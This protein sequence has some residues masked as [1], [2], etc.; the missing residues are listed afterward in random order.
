VSSDEPVEMTPE[1]RELVE[2]RWREVEVADLTPRQAEQRRLAEQMRAVIDHLVATTAPEEALRYAADVLQRLAVEFEAY[3][4]ANTY[5]GF[6]EAANA[7]GDQ[8]AFF[9]HSPLI[10]QAN[11]LA[12]PVVIR[13]EDDHIDG[14]VTFGAAYE[15]PPGCVHGGYLAAAFD[16]VLGAA[17]SLGGRPGMTGTLTIRYRAPTPLH[18]PLRFVAGVTAVEGRKIFTSGRCFAD[19]VLTAEAE[20]VFISVSR[21][22]VDELRALRDGT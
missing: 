22:R 12:P 13:V 20:G 7:G 6:A 18:T 10:G 2:Q 17:Q 8:R 1:V 21:E 16:E 3:P 11:P 19:D 14:R 4:Q 15:G 5:E 9:D